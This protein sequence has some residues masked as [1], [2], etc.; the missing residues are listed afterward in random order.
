MS[1]IDD[2]KPIFIDQTCTVINIDSRN[3]LMC[4]IH[5][6]KAQNRRF[7]VQLEEMLLN[8][9]SHDLRFPVGSL[10]RFKLSLPCSVTYLAY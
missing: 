3:F 9:H 4:R 8:L 6:Y 7:I 1:S 10:S 2:A 5:D